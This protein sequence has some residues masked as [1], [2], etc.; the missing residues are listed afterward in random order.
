MVLFVVKINETSDV[1]ELL[2]NEFNRKR[3]N[4]ESQMASIDRT[5]LATAMP[6]WL[7]YRSYTEAAAG[8]SCLHTGEVSEKPGCKV[9]R[10][11]EAL[12][13]SL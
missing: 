3:V 2:N 7:R 9:V 11:K 12:E 10:R 6:P 1:P 5:P 8:G 4:S 13:L